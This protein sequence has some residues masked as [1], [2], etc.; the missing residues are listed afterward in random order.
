MLRVSSVAQLVKPHIVSINGLGGNKQDYPITCKKTNDGGFILATFTSSTVGAITNIC[1]AG[2]ER[3]IFEKFN[4]TGNDIEWSRCYQATNDTSF[5]FLFTEADGSNILIGSNNSFSSNAQTILVRKE[6]ILGNV[7]WN[8]QYGG[9]STDRLKD[10]LPTA[11]GGYILLCETYS[12]DGDVGHHYGSNLLADFWIFKIDGNGNIIWSKVIGG[13]EE[14]Q[15]K[16]LTTASNGGFY[17]I[18]STLSNDFDCTGTHNPGSYFDAYLARFDSEG[19]KIWHRCLG[20]NSGTIGVDICS[21]DKGGVYV[22]SATSAGGGDVK[23]YLG[24]TDFWLVRIDSSNSIKLSKCYGTSAGNENPYSISFASSN[25]IWMV[26]SSAVVGKHVNDAFGLTDGYILNVDTLGDYLMSIVVG[27]TSYDDARVVIPTEDRG[28]FVSGS[29][30][31]LGTNL[32]PKFEGEKDVYKI[33]L[34]P[35]ETG[36]RGLNTDELSVSIYPNP[37][38]DWIFIENSQNTESDIRIK[39]I[40]GKEILSSVAT[41]DKAKLNV[42]SLASG[43]YM[44]YITIGDKTIV[45][46]VVKSN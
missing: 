19:N 41:T 43:I 27:S 11:D 42:S 3:I 44:V 20:G 28:I 4:P 34:A 6:D 21:D 2:D 45:R 33:K 22:L 16:K 36:V 1:N 40:L 18:G 37:T 14:E 8:K 38:N 30:E 7:V 39:D 17:I 35:W 9:S 12:S 25:S 23:E 24:N 31:G 46:K 29:Y 5:S 10:V 26:G 13:S 15:V 32:P